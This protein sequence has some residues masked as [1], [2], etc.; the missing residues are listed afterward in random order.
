MDYK[1]FQAKSLEEALEQARIYYNIDNDKIDTIEYEVVDEGSKGFLGVFGS[2]DVVIR[3]KYV[4]PYDEV[5]EEYLQKIFDIL[6]IDAKIEKSFVN[7]G[8]I[9]K[10]SVIGDEAGVLIGR[11]GDA[12]RSLQLLITNAVSNQFK[13]YK[14][15]ILDIEN[16]R[17]KR[18][19][20]L[21]RFANKIANKA[22]DQKRSIRLEPMVP[23][24]RR[25]IHTALQD[26]EDITTFSEGKDPYR[27]VVISYKK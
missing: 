21:I 6:D 4:K 16:Y 15:I 17:Q 25:I 2:K 12:M 20:S 27:R 9:L 19:N 5:A 14:K 1:E 8:K 7:D 10:L 24:E 11:R 3:A 22:K 23:Y 18:E 26:M 13:E